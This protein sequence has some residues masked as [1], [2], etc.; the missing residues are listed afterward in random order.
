MPPSWLPFTFSNRASFEPPIALIA[1]G[2]RKMSYG[3]ARSSPSFAAKFTS[4]P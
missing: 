2:V 1:S 3:P 4:T